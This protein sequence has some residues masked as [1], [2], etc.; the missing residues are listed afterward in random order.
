MK[1]VSENGDFDVTKPGRT[2][3]VSSIARRN[4][5]IQWIDIGAVLGRTY[6]METVMDI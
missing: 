4:E 1:I 2:V 6:E 3:S 5:V